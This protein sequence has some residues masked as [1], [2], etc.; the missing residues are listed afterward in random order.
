VRGTA[1]DED[2]FRF[3]AVAGT[4]YVLVNND[5]GWANLE[6]LDENFSP[7][8]DALEYFDVSD[9]WTAPATGTYYLK[10][11]GAQ[12]RRYGFTGPYSFSLFE[13]PLEEQSSK[14]LPMELGSTLTGVFYY[15]A[16]YRT[17]TLNIPAGDRYRLVMSMPAWGYLNL[18]HL[19]TNYSYDAPAYED[20]M[21]SRSFTL[22]PGQYE[23]YI[24]AP[25]AGPFLLLA[26]LASNFKIDPATDDDEQSDEDEQ[27]AE[28]EEEGDFGDEEILFDHA[29]DNVDSDDVGDWSWD[30]GG[31]WLDDSED[32]LDS[33]DDELW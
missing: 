24:E 8:P 20:G 18:T 11:F 21:I 19:K 1:S 28:D 26:D 3:H 17:F 33:F 22:E 15:P 29:L 27:F 7:V 6:L 5:E 31:D 16:D 32:T 9:R 25:S 2:F 10:V 14:P 13:A 12:Y 4:T 30:D 23:V